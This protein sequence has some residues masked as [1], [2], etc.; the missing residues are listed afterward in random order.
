M[1]AVEG[2]TCRYGAIEATRDVDLTVAQGEI[3]TLIG[4]N[5]AGKTSVLG[6]ISGLVSHTGTITFD[7]AP[8]PRAPARVVRAGVVQVPEGRE[9]FGQLTVEENLRMGGYARRG[10]KEVARELE[11]Q[12]ERFPALAERRRL[13]AASLS[14][15]Q[16]QMLAIARAMLSRPRLL[17]LDEPSLGLAPVLVR[18]IMGTIRRLNAEEGLTVLLVEQS[19]ALA[20]AAASRGYVLERGRVVLSG[21]AAE[22]SANPQVRSAYLGLGERAA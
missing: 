5:G 20:L 11:A 16:Q 19:V 21:P 2:L 7:G 4:A 6:A 1:L 22:L 17:M 9:L 18:E 15:G 13:P 12:L 10:R 14:G 3:V 8:L